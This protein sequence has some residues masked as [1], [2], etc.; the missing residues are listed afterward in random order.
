MTLG[1]LM[2]KIPVEHSQTS[3]KTFIEVLRGNN[4]MTKIK[5]SLK[6]SHPSVLSQLQKL[7]KAG[8]F[9][10]EKSG[11]IKVYEISWEKLKFY[12]LNSIIRPVVGTDVIG[13]VEVMQRDEFLT[14]LVEYFYKDVVLSC[15]LNP[16]VEVSTEDG[17]KTLKDLAKSDM[18][19]VDFKNI[20]E[21]SRKNMM[22]EKFYL[23]YKQYPLAESTLHE[24]LLELFGFLSELVKLPDGKVKFDEKFSK[25]MEDFKKIVGSME[26]TGMYK[27]VFFAKL[28]QRFS[29]GG[30]SSFF[31]G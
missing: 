31:N 19:F 16:I 18:T 24:S 13:I 26:G 17:T 14:N 21:E 11:R 3:W 6:I 28:L 22:D 10:S 29:K 12:L 23:L 8:Y 27:R 30:T 25:F 4:T 20:V 5:K 9:L 2:V 15:V 7:E 1:F